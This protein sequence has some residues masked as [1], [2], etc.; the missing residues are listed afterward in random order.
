VEYICLHLKVSQKGQA[1][2]VSL[3]WEEEVNRF[4]GKAISLLANIRAIEVY[5]KAVETLVELAS[6]Q[7]LSSF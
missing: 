7:V 1:I 4:K 5:T 6:L 2:L 3:V